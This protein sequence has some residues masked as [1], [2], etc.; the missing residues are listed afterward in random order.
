MFSPDFPPHLKQILLQYF[1]VACEACHRGSLLDHLLSERE[2]SRM[3]GSEEESATFKFA[4]LIMLQITRGLVY[5][6][7]AHQLPHGNLALSNI[8]LDSVGL[9]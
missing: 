6:H 7:S 1:V 2:H 8:L 3:S 9:F 5:L 4:P